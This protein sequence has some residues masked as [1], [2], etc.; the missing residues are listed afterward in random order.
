M[1]KSGDRGDRG[2][3]EP[4]RMEKSSTR[5]S[6]S[7]YSQEGT[8]RTPETKSGKKSRRS[9]WGVKPKSR[10]SEKK[11]STT[12]HSKNGGESS[13]LGMQ[14]VKRDSPDYESDTLR[15]EAYERARN[16][17]ENP[18]NMD[19]GSDSEYAYYNRP[20]APIIDNATSHTIGISE[21]MVESQA[22]WEQD[23]MHGGYDALNG[24]FRK[25]KDT[26]GTYTYTWNSANPESEGAML[27]QYERDNRYR[28]F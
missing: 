21:N 14:D 4:K 17:P 25:I 15:G 18:Y 13:S 20:S 7:I 9:L 27:A 5:D 3:D 8:Y 23:G 19:S 16:M 10:S 11:R 6:G 22:R 2:Y 1:V 28:S 12:E 26:N 24:L